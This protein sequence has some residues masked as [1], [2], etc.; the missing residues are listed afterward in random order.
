MCVEN[1]YKYMKEQNSSESVDICIS[2]FTSAEH[3]Y[4]EIYHV[5]QNMKILK[6]C[7]V[8]RECMKVNALLKEFASLGA[9][10]FP[11][12]VDLNL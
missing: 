2:L 10:S 9:N 7:H 6:T 5:M 3:R 4:I 11:L 12:R 8:T 1:V